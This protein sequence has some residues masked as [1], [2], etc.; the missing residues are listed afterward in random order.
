VKCTYFFSC[1]SIVN[2][3]DELSVIIAFSV[4]GNGMVGAMLVRMFNN[5]VVKLLWQMLFCACVFTLQVNHANAL[6]GGGNEKAKQVCHLVKEN[7]VNKETPECGWYFGYDEELHKDDESK[8]VP[9][10]KKMSNE[11]ASSEEQEEV[12]VEKGAVEENPCATAE[13]WVAPCGFV[14]PQG[15]FDFQAIQ[16]DA[17]LQA[18]AM[19][20]KDTD[21]VEGLQ[22]YMKWAVN[23]AVLM[24]KMWRYNMVQNTELDATVDAPVSAFG[25]RLSSGISSKSRKSMFSIINDAGGFLVFFSR[26]DCEYCHEILPLVQRL[27]QD[28]SIS[29][30]NASLDSECLKGFTDKCMVA[31]DTILPAQILQVDIVPAIFLYLPEDESW[32]RISTGIT[33]VKEMESRIFNFAQAIKTATKAGNNVDGTGKAA[34]DFDGKSLFERANSVGLAKGIKNES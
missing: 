32:V 24:T 8:K 12:A 16:R 22:Y 21:A 33:P 27:H 10:V 13:T 3:A 29:V 20:P 18:A 6:V 19:N 34:V 11:E 4:E 15:D 9:V 14:D 30:W 26:S 25:L 17:L 1:L 5:K 2:R 23:Q 7:G 28:T 31:P